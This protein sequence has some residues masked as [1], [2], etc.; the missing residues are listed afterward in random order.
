MSSK[1][2]LF[3]FSPGGDPALRQSV[4][5]RRCST[6]VVLIP[7]K[8]ARREQNDLLDFAVTVPSNGHSG[9]GQGN[10]AGVTERIEGMPALPVGLLPLQAQGISTNDAFATGTDAYAMFQER[11][12]VWANGTTNLAWTRALNITH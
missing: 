5:D 11:R 2:L 12:V 8:V 3:T 9:N 7:Q 6:S 1:L 4:C 10:W